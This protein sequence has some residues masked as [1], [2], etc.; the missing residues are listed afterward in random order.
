[1]GGVAT[2]AA[3][4]HYLAT[5]GGTGGAYFLDTV[6]HGFMV[7][8]HG[9]YGGYNDAVAWIEQDGAEGG[10]HGGT[11]GIEYRLSCPSG[12]ITHGIYGRA[13]GYVDQ[14]GSICIQ[15]STQS[16]QYTSA[17]GGSGGAYFEE[18][19]SPGEGAVGL[20]GRSGGYVDQLGL[21]CNANGR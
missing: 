20:Q 18:R 10:L 11:G 3:G 9:R 12:W 7:G 4:D 19:C 14:L 13:G 17:K 6:S 1:M 15:Q 21:V 5:Y 2:A 16:E 8:F